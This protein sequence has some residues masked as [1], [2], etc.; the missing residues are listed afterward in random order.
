MSDPNT[1]NSAPNVGAPITASTRLSIKAQIA[2]LEALFPPELDHDSW[3]KHNGPLTFQELADV[4]YALYHR[5]SRADYAVEK[6]DKKPFKITGRHG[7]LVIPND[8]VRQHLL[9]KLRK[10]GR[11]NKWINAIPRTKKQLM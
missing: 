4:R 11:K 2:K 5:C 9:W 3:L 7:T 6:T 1:A 8:E 10:L